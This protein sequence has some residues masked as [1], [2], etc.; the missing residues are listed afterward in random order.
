[1]TWEGAVEEFLKPWRKRPDV[2]GALVCGSYV[3][4]TASRAEQLRRRLHLPVPHLA[5]IPDRRIRLT[6]VAVAEHAKR[7]GR[8]VVRP[9]PR[10]GA[11]TKYF[12][13]IGMSHHR[14]DT[15]V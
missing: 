2:V 13:V 12:R 11:R 9:G 7:N 14:Q 4:S 8:T 10:Q 5:E 3:T 6:L 1:M 15:F